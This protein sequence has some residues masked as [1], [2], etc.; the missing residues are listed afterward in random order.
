MSSKKHSLGRPNKRGRAVQENPTQT[1]KKVPLLP[2][3]PTTRAAA[4]AA[5]GG[6]GG[7]NKRKRQEPA[8]KS[9]SKKEKK[10]KPRAEATEEPA[11]AAESS[12]DSEF[13]YNEQEEE[14]E[15]EDEEDE[16]VQEENENEKE[17]QSPP[18]LVKKGDE[19]DADDAEKEPPT[20]KLRAE[21]ASAT[22]SSYSSSSFSD[23]SSSSSS[24]SSTSSSPTDISAPFVPPPPSSSLFDAPLSDPAGLEVSDGKGQQVASATFSSVFPREAPPQIAVAQSDLDR[25]T[26]LGAAAQMRAAEKASFSSFS[27]SASSSSFNKTAEAA[28][29]SRQLPDLPKTMALSRPAPPRANGNVHSVGA[30]TSAAAPRNGQHSVPSTAPASS[31]TTTTTS[32]PFNLSPQQLAAEIFD[33][34]KQV[35]K[36]LWYGHQ[37]VVYSTALGKELE[38]RGIRATREYPVRFQYIPT[39]RSLSLSERAAKTAAAT[40]WL[41]PDPFQQPGATLESLRHYVGEGY[42]DLYLP[43]LKVPLEVKHI[44]SELGDSEEGQLRNYMREL[45]APYGFLIN[46]P[47]RKDQLPIVKLVQNNSTGG[48][49]LPALS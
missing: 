17:N 35:C 36:Q 27:S 2:R 39:S 42:V 46:F 13:Y 40:A 29:Q 11:F 48:T 45:C 41:P 10:S 6:S 16:K 37:E 4:T 44:L 20:K 1:Q 47:K 9:L 30:P 26:A 22:S 32:Y 23:P 34:A 8:T 21:S 28:Q 5:H 19:A 18:L 25:M 38:S 3:G 31:P 12:D 15:E 24:S 43:Q 14:E 49:V 33:S 7:N